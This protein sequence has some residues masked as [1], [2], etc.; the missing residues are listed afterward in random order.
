MNGFKP[1]FVIGTGRSGTST[2]ARLL[3]DNFDINMGD[4]F[5][6]ANDDN[7]SGFYEDL[8]LKRL[9]DRMLTSQMR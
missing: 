2:V 4:N 8:D 6:P 7:P 1:I 5:R 3:H 9:N